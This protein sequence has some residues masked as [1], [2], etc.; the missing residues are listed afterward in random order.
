MLQRAGFS[1]SVVNPRQI[2]DF[3]RAM[4]RLA[5]TDRIDAHTIALFAEKIQPRETPKTSEN[6]D[7]M[8]ALRTR[9]QQVVDSIVREQNRLATQDDPDIRRLI[10]Q[11]IDLYK[12]QRERIEK[13]LSK[14]LAKDVKLQQTVERLQT[15]PGIGETTAN[16]LVLEL[17]ELGQLNRQQIARLAGVAPTNRDSGTLRGKRTTG[18]GRASVRNALFM[19]TLVA[20][21]WNPK[22]RDFYQRLIKRGKPKMTALIAALRKLLTIINVMVKNQTDW[23]PNPLSS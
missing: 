23:N 21:R 19:A 5:K 11:A 7:K 8:R 3:A 6:T 17:P 15:V 10:Q 16:T 22:I 9:R 13:Q 18:G 20:T 12:K 1:V 2:R 4:N 14:Y